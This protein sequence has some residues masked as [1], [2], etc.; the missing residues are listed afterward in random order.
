MF[1]ADSLANFDALDSLMKQDSKDSKVD[2]DSDLIS[3]TTSRT[4]ATQDKT[5][6]DIGNPDELNPDELRMAY[7]R[8]QSMMM[9]D[10]P[11]ALL[12]YDLDAFKN[13]MWE[14]FLGS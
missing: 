14:N 8:K 5:I 6:D 4:N 13:S 3:N 10:K 9:P 12:N 1:K 7:M 11:N 2:D